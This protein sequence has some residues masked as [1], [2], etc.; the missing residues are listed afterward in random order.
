ME[1][2]WSDEHPR[3][4]A[5]C[6]LGL[7][8][9]LSEEM[10]RSP[11]KVDINLAYTS[12]G[13]FLTGVTRDE[14]FQMHLEAKRLLS[15]PE[16]HAASVAEI[17][18]IQMIAALMSAVG[19]RDFSWSR[20]LVRPESR[21]AIHVLSGIIHFAS[22]REEKLKRYNEIQE[23]Q[24]FL[25]NK[26]DS[27]LA[28][29]QQLENIRNRCQQEYDQELPIYQRFENEVKE[30]RVHIER[31]N[32]EQARLTDEGADLKAQLQSIREKN[33]LISQEIE[34][35]KTKTAGIR[36]FIL[37]NPEELQAARAERENSLNREK[38]F[39]SGADRGCQI[40]QQQM[41]NL[42]KLQKDFEET[43][44]LLEQTNIERERAEQAKREL[45]RLEGDKLQLASEESEL[46]GSVKL[47][48]M[49][50][51]SA[52][53]QI[54]QFGEQLKN[55]RTHHAGVMGELMKE[56]AAVE[57]DRENGASG[58]RYAE[59]QRQAKSYKD[60]IDRMTECHQYEVQRLT[61]RFHALASKADAYAQQLVRSLTSD[62]TA[63]ASRSSG[64]F[65]SH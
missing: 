3:Y 21:R 60:E 47:M 17:A 2:T 12:L 41:T 62:P 9:N 40:L 45:K 44:V 63:D 39:I 18:R 11:N 25:T 61:Q 20:D 38:S 58:Q 54:A 13:Q 8:I 16:I 10:L 35:V 22:F 50:I 49:Q 48:S 24:A 19:L 55:A 36:A 28:Q 33:T 52:R 31:L 43:I 51:E 30:A 1:I 56:M 7:N 32:N 14:L 57:Q 53:S 34:A 65:S 23:E 59:L 29:R 6:L 64:H 37:D 27:L 15:Y 42:H 5:E 4:I 26:R 46:A